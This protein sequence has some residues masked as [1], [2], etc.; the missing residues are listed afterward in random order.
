MHVQE[1]DE[2]ERKVQKNL[3]VSVE[4]LVRSAI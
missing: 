4:K 3:N 2:K 1:M